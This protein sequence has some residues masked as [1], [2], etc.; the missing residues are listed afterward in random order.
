LLIAS[1]RVR[2]RAE[3][4]LNSGGV[5]HTTRATAV[6]APGAALIAAGVYLSLLLLSAVAVAVLAAV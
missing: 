1:F 3:E 4:S 6:L 5:Q 2:C